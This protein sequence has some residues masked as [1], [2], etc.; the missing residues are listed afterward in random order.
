MICNFLS[1]LL[2]TYDNTY[3]KKEKCYI[4]C[5]LDNIPYHYDLSPV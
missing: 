4:K 5:H 3:N 2:L 1:I